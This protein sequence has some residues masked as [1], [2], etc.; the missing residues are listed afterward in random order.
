MTKEIYYGQAGQDSVIKQ[1]FNYKG[2]TKGIF[3]DVGA[4]DGIRYSNSYSLE[5]SGWT[6]ICVEM[7]PSYYDLLVKN[8]PNS[9]C[10]NCGAAGEN[11]DE[12]EVSLNWRASLSTID[13]DLENYYQTAYKD[14]YGDRDTK[15]I[16]GFL[17]GRH[18]VQLRTLNSILDENAE[19]FPKINFVSVGID[20]SEKDA[21]PQLD[22]TKC[23]PEL[24]C[25][26]H[27]L[28]GEEFITRYAQQYGFVPARRIG[29]DI[30]FVKD[31]DDVNLIRS[32]GLVGEKHHNEHIC[33]KP[34]KIT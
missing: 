8:R 24:V 9:V 1:Y 15:E 19:R 33:D 16:N 18:K 34:Q 28:V 30:L 26:E 13:L 22:L 6:G 29:P 20:G 10:Y 5:K 2:I 14:W 23:N 4:S 3:M 31:P 21:L 12:A 32:F 11:K 7:H 17:N 27:E 25:I